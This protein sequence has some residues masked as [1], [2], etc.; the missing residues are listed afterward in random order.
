[1]PTYFAPL[2]DFIYSYKTG[3]DWP[4]VYNA[5]AGDGSDTTNNARMYQNLT[6]LNYTLA[7][8]GVNFDLSSLGIPAYETVVQV[9]VIGKGRTRHYDLG[10]MIGYAAFFPTSAALPFDDTIYDVLL[11]G[12]EYQHVVL[13]DG[14][15]YGAF[16]CDL[17]AQG[18][19]DVIA[20]IA[21]DGVFKL[22][23]RGKGDVEDITPDS[24]DVANTFEM[25]EILACL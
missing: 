9:Q 19:I 20:H 4:T 13:H 12:S 25:Q 18:V 24:G 21:G 1:M 11:M 3:T 2:T 7:R 23:I 17:G 15:V 8:A 22:A 10:Y 6:G 14:A 16:A 5:A